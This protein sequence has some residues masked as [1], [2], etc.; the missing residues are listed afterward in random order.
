[1]TLTPLTKMR[2]KR[3]EDVKEKKKCS[4]II[5]I[6]RNVG[7]RHKIPFTPT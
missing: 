3:G 5:N 4:I 1:M 7:G 2:A 6:S